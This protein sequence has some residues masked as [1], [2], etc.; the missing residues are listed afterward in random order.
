[1]KQQQLFLTTK[2]KFKSL[3]NRV[4]PVLCLL[5][6]LLLPSLIT[7]CSSDATAPAAQPKTVAETSPQ[8][9]LETIS[10][11]KYYSLFVNMAK[12][13]KIPGAAEVDRT[14]STHIVGVGPDYSFGSRTFL[15]L[16]GTQSGKVTQQRIVFK[17]TDQDVYT[18]I[19]LVYTKESLGKDM[20]FWPTKSIDTYEKESFL[21]K[22][23]E[24]MLSY[25]NVLIK[26]TRISKTKPLELTDMQ[27][28]IE[29]VTTFMKAT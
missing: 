17:D 23:D 10:Y 7:G 27:A 28:A 21:K 5:P 29:A 14:D 25:N 24:C 9:S 22:Y 6:I 4:T 20:V 19:D 2:K 26:I 12:T 11:D 18:F 3:S 15:T 8:A 16:D 1:M 13:L